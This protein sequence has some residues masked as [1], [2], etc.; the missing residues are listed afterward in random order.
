LI[1]LLPDISY[2]QLSYIGFP[3]PNQEITKQTKDPVFMASIFPTLKKPSFRDRLIVDKESDI[4]SKK[5][6]N[7]NK[8]E[9]NMRDNTAEN[10]IQ[11]QNDQF[12]SSSN[13]ATG[14]NIVS[15]TKQKSRLKE[16]NTIEAHQPLVPTVYVD[17]NNS[18]MILIEKKK[19]TPEISHLISNNIQ[20]QE[21]EY[22]YNNG[23][24]KEINFVNGYNSKALTDLKVQNNLQLSMKSQENNQKNNSAKNK[25]QTK[26]E[27]KKTKAKVENVDATFNVNQENLKSS[28]FEAVNVS[29]GNKTYKTNEQRAS[30][31]KPSNGIENSNK[32]VTNQEYNISQVNPIVSSNVN[33][34]NAGLNNTNYNKVISTTNKDDEPKVNSNLSKRKVDRSFV[35]SDEDSDYCEN[36]RPIKEIHVLKTENN[37]N[38]KNLKMFYDHR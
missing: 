1:S 22:L 31:K 20:L 14:N 10:L 5:V 37:K 29:N 30:E 35:S 32:L 7:N 25:G 18:Q 23:N 36:V 26:K 9:T 27:D 21:I 17:N 2:K 15:I 24:S 34:S 3:N 28:K 19:T 8:V 4:I 13:K 16:E 6:N 11:N 33:N 38:Q 12:K